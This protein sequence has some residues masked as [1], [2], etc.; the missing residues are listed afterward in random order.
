MFFGATAI[1]SFVIIVGIFA[2]SY[3]I[4]PRKLSWMS[5]VLVTVLLAVLAYHLEPNNTDDL[6][7]YFSQIDQI[8]E[9]GY[10][11]VRSCIENKTFE[12]NVF[13]VNAYYFYLISLLPNNYY[14]AAITLFIVYGLMFLIIYKASVRFNVNKTYTF[15]ASMFFLSTYWFYDTASGIRNGL[16]F[17]IIFACSYYHL[18]ERKRIALSIIGYLLA[19]FLHSTGIILVSFILLTIITLNNDGK[20]FNY[21]LVFMLA[22]GSFIFDYL[23]SN[24]NSAYVGSISD[25]IKSNE[26]GEKINSYTN[27]TVNIVT[28]AVVALLL[29]YVS[30]FITRYDLDFE[31]KRFYKF[32]TFIAYS[33]LG[34]IYSSLLFMRFTRWLFPIIGALYF[35]IGMQIIKDKVEEKGVQYFLY[36]APQ[37]EAV[38]VK[39]FSLS[40]IT[41]IVYTVIHFWYLVNGSSVVWMHFAYEVAQ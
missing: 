34:T 29:I 27:F 40:I 11:F 22:I 28:F 32:T 6:S 13:R 14:L 39:L 33:T 17:A 26:V 15:F 4:L 31:M 41:Y 9:Q 1:E 2:V 23:K 36:F 30:Y 3:W 25:R 8:R 20:Y 7:R 21:I 35:M 12:W 5:F 16:A 38:R 19:I 10:D 37:R 24:T 18:V